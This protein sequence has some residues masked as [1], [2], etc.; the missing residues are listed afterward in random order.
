MMSVG[1]EM[2]SERELYDESSMVYFMS[3]YKRLV[4]AL[5]NL[6]FIQIQKYNKI[7]KNHFGHLHTR[8]KEKK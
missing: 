3:T 8:I 1:C 6:H 4:F 5:L 2:V 7:N